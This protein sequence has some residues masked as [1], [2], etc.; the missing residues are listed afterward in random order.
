MKRGDANITTFCGSCYAG[1]HMCGGDCECGRYYRERAFEY[2]PDLPPRP[3]E[4]L[5]EEA[6]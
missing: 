6:K 2:S 4:P 3:G 5:D 1:E